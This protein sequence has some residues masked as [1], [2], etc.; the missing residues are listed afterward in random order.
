MRNMQLSESRWL[1]LVHTRVILY[2][3][4]VYYPQEGPNDGLLRTP[5]GRKPIG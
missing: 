1:E 3:I 4:S 5:P 2:S